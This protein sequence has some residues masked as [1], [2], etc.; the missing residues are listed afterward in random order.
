MSSNSLCYHTRDKKIRLGRDCIGIH[1]VLRLPIASVVLN[2][3]SF[4]VFRV[5]FES[6]SSFVFLFIFHFVLMI[7]CEINR[8]Q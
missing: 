6:F 8:F 4:F 7:L 1:S 2:T 3:F 5:N